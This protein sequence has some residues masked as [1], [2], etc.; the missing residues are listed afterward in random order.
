MMETRACAR[1][2]ETK[3][4]TLEFFPPHKMGKCG[5]HSLCRPCKKV[6]DAELRV[7]PDQIARQQAW[8]DAN[9]D[10][11]KRSNIAYRAGGY[12]STAA[13]A[14]WRA[15]NLAH[16]RK[17]EA[18][19]RRER[20]AND[21]AFRLRGRLSARLSSL[22]C[23]KAGKTTEQLLGFTRHELTRHIEKQFI[24]GMSW[25]AFQRGL[26]EIDHIIPVSRFNITSTD[27]PEF[28][29]CWGLPNLRPMWAKDNRSKGAKVLTL[30]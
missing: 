16:S 26:I 14:K 4:A 11:V 28:R 18:R 12:R 2:A 25:D 20:R 29:A 17:Q 23:G 6:R 21:P 7:R 5:L 13:V 24:N 22:I 9:K 1:C 3:P 15:E 10:A 27:D 8:R 30:I 19:R